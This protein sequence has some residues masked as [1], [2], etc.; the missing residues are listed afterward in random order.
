MADQNICSYAYKLV[1]RI[2]DKFS[3]PIKLYRDKNAA[4]KFI[5]DMLKEEKYYY[6]MLK[7]ISIKKS[8]N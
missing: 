6:N 7:T 5:V 1:C 3:K 4:Y 2:N 8:Y